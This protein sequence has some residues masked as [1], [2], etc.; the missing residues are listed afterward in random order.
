MAIKDGRLAAIKLGHRT[1]IP[2]ESLRAWIATA[3]PVRRKT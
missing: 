2:A 1:L 3:R